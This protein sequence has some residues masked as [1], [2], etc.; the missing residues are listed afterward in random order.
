MKNIYSDELKKDLS[1][2]KIAKGLR[3]ILYPDL[4]GIDVE[5]ISICLLC[6]LLIE[7]GINDVLYVWLSYDMPSTDKMDEKKIKMDLWKEITTMNFATKY[8]VILPSFSSFFERPSKLVWKINDL[9]NDIFHGR[10]LKN[11]KFNGKAINSE[12]AIEDL[13]TTAQEI[14]SYLVKFGELLDG[15]RALAEKWARRLEKL[16]EPLL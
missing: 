1:M 5:I 11:A 8:R 14:A 12:N 10:S 9:R 6:H 16:G 15:R 3:Q 13:F 2:Q 4:I 7:R